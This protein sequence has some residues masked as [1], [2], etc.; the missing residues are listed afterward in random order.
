MSHDTQ[1]VS[2]RSF[3]QQ[4]AM[5]GAV[6]MAAPYFV[7][8]HALA[9]ATRVGA[10]DRLQIGLIGAGGMGMGNLANC[11]AH[12][13]VVVTAI[14]DVWKERRDAACAQ[15]P[16]AK[17]YADYREMLQ[18]QDVDAVIIAT[19]PHWHCLIAVAACAAGKDIYLQKP[20]TLHVA[21]TLAIKQ[22]VKRH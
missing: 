18:Q 11:A 4:T 1:T 10:N 12:Q 5:A 2:R 13:D 14:C 20:M 19:P 16:T 3:M 8:A 15:Y 17:P 21:E 6:G 22:A 9:S 7:P